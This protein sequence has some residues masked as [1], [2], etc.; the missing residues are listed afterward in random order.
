M[1]RNRELE[2]YRDYLRK[3]EEDDLIC[4]STNINGSQAEGW[5]AKNEI[6]RDFCA[7]SKADIA[8]FQEVNFN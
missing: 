2:N 8:N 6:A 4:L 7:Q 3:E 5:K 1:N